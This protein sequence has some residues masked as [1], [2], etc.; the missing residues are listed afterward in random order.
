MKFM[1]MRPQGRHP[2]AFEPG[3]QPLGESASIATSV[4]SSGDLLGEKPT[5][6]SVGEIQVKPDSAALARCRPQGATP[7]P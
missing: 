4:P 6:I 7:A 5:R 2:R 1:K 3:H